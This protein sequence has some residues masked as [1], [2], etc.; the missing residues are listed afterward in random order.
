MKNE[1]ERRIERLTKGK[2]DSLST[3]QTRDCGKREQEE[4]GGEKKK[5]RWGEGER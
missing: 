1:I 5:G 3:I 2:R 4:K